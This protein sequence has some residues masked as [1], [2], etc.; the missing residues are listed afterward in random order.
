M[1]GDLVIW[2]S[3]KCKSSKLYAVASFEN[4]FCHDVTVLIHKLTGDADSLFRSSFYQLSR[5]YSFGLV[6]DLPVHKIRSLCPD[7]RQ[8]TGDK[9]PGIPIY[10]HIHRSTAA[11]ESPSG[12]GA[13]ADTIKARIGAAG[14]S[15][16]DHGPSKFRKDNSH[17]ELSQFGVRDRYGL[18]TWCDWPGSVKCKFI[19]GNQII[20]WSSSSTTAS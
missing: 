14:A 16:D 3:P 15:G 6:S 18:D 2:L 12:N 11:A 5:T 7:S 4:H 19:E 10:I 8:N 13:P 17:E 9:P 20:K 1:T